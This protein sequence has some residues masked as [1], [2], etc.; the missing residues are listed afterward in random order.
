MTKK[1]L[2]NWIM[3]HQTQKLSI[4]GFSSKRIAR[5]MG[6]DPRTIRKYLAMTEQGFEQHLINLA[7]RNKV[8]SDYE[9]FVK[10]KLTTFPDTTTAQIHDWLKEHH[11][12][13]PQVSTKTVYNFVMYVRQVHNI[14]VV[15]PT[16]E[17]LPVEELPYG[18]QA[19]V[20]FGEYNMRTSDG[21]RKKVHFF[22]MVLSRSRMKYI[23]FNDRPFIAQTVCQAHENA[24]AF[25]NGVPNTLVYDQDKTMLVDENLGELLLTSVFKQYT[26]SRSFKLH[27]CRKSDPESKGKIENVIQYVKKN[28]LYNRAY[29]DQESLNAEA[30]GWLGRTANYLPHNFTKKPP[31]SEFAIE[32]QYLNSFT[33]M[34]IEY[35][36]YKAYNVRKVNTINYKSNFYELPVGTYKGVGTMVY[37]RDKDN[38]LEICNLKKELIRSCPVSALKGQN[39]PLKDRRRDTSKTVEEMMNQVAD[40]FTNKEQIKDFIQQIRNKYPRYTRDH[41]QTI[42]KAISDCDQDVKDKTLEFCINNELFNGSDFEQVCLVHFCEVQIPKLQQTMKLLNERNLEKAS[43]APQMSNIEDYEI[44]INQ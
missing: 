34:V 7:T 31:Y 16:R 12:D 14:P 11:P 32:Q 44:I 33:P 38:V 30:L 27:F 22:A 39:I 15:K 26:K 29:S 20:D 18:E 35:D 24:F 42:L 28:F 43:Q 6:L 3:Y 37:V 10:D 9:S 36:D 5:Y 4:L 2:N 19:Q 21:K 25:F 17:Y 41:L 8:L 13:F 40:N 23:W 1:D